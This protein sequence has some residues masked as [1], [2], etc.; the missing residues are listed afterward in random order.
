M[1]NPNDTIGNQSRDLPVCSAAPQP[2][3]HRVPH[4]EDGDKFFFRNDGIFLPTISRHIAANNNLYSLFREDIS[5]RNVCILRCY[6]Y[7]LTEC[8]TG[9]LLI[10]ENHSVRWRNGRVQRRRLINKFYRIMV[11]STE[12]FPS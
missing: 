10:Q 7:A 12:E 2:L 9:A 1:K 5:C 4:P 3:R 8:M 6:L 11:N